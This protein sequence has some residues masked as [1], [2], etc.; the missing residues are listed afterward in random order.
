MALNA[1]ALSHPMHMRLCTYLQPRQW[2]G[3]LPIEPPGP[4]QR[5]VDGVDAVG[6]ADDH[7]AAAG[8]QA[9][10]EGQQGGDDGVVD[11]VLRGRGGRRRVC[12][13]GGIGPGQGGAVTG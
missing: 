7:H 12:E 1:R 8:V 9:V 10:H 3:Q 6:G 2:E 13:C 4:P 5:S 11:L